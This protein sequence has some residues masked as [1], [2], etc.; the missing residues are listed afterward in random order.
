MRRASSKMCG[1][2]CEMKKRLIPVLTAL[3]AIVLIA[4]TCRIT[5]V[6]DEAPI[7]MV[8]AAGETVTIEKLSFTEQYTVDNW[9]AKIIPT[10]QERAVDAT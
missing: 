1:E 3:L 8:N 4:A 7:T 2:G 5:I 9:D 10:I 6:P